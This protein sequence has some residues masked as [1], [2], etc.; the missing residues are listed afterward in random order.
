M[1]ALCDLIERKYPR[2]SFDVLFVSA[3]G[4]SE[5]SNHPRVKIAKVGWGENDW[6]D[7]TERWK[8]ATREWQEVLLKASQDN[9][10]GPAASAPRG[11]AGVVVVDKKGCVL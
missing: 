5:V 3:G 11:M 7:P 9:P 10:S 4:G 6:T 2:I 8:G 1:E